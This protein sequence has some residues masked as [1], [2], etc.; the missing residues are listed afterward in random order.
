MKKKIIFL[1]GFR[2]PPS[3]PIRW[4]TPV[5]DRSCQCRHLG[6]G[7]DC[8]STRL[9]RWKRFHICYITGTAIL[10]QSTSELD[11]CHPLTFPPW[12]DIMNPG[13][14]E[15]LYSGLMLIGMPHV[16][17][18]TMCMIKH[19]IFFKYII[20]GSPTSLKRYLIQKLCKKK[21]FVAKM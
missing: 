9:D 4:G 21:E 19:P 7:F 11:F 10:D 12:S 5:Q 3:P 14:Q 8:T 16:H 17:C 20:I 2:T 6:K 18:S 15:Y 13:A 1:L